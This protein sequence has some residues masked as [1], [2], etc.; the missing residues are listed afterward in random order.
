LSTFLFKKNVHWKFHKEL[1]KALLKQQKRIKRPR[2]CLDLIMK[3][4]ECRAAEY[5]MC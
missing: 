1:Q 2:K 5:S 4:A 3:V